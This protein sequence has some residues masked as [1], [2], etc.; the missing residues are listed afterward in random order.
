MCSKEVSTNYV[1]EEINY[2]KGHSVESDPIPRNQRGGA[3]QL[4]FID[5]HSLQQMFLL[6]RFVHES[7][8][9]NN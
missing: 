7:S 8:A 5:H 3:E 1:Y 9:D 4:L 6:I 2:K